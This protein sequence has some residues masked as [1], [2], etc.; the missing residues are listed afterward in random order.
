MFRKDSTELENFIK[1]V[2]AQK[3]YVIVP[4]SRYPKLDLGYA[5]NTPP[6]KEEKRASRS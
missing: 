1:L 5:K 3:E 2:Q 6:P 4:L